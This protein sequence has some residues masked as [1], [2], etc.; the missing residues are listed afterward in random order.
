MDESMR[1]KVTRAAAACRTGG[2]RQMEAALAVIE[3]GR[4]GEMQ[5]VKWESLRQKQEPRWRIG[6]VA[7]DLQKSKA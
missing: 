5:W 1:A 7:T 6:R 4:T 3:Q 2:S